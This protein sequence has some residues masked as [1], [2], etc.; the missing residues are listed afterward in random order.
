MKTVKLLADS[1]GA[2]YKGADIAFKGFSIDSRTLKPGEIFVALPNVRDGHDFIADAV[3]KGAAAVLVSKPVET[4][5]PTI[6]VQNTEKALGALAKVW[7]EQFSLPILAITGSSGKTTVKHLTAAILQRRYNT[8]V[9]PK[10]LNNHL[11]LPLVLGQ[12]TAEHDVAVLEMGA[13]LPGEIGYLADIAEPSVGL[14]TLVNPCHIE[15]FGSVESI[16]HTKG[17]L[18]SHLKPGSVALINQADPFCG[19]WTDMASHC[20]RLFFSVDEPSDFYAREIRVASESAEFELVTPEG[21][22]EIHLPLPGHHNVQ[23]A[24]CAAALALTAGADLNTIQQGLQSVTSAERRLQIKKISPTLWII[25]DS[26]NA[27]PTT[28]SIALDI[29][30]AYPARKLCFMGDMGELLL[31]E[32]RELHAAVGHKA[33]EVG[34]EA[35]YGVGILSQEACR[36]FGPKAHNFATQA[37][38]LEV[39][40][41]LLSDEP[42]I[43]LVKGSRGAKMDVVADAIVNWGVRLSSRV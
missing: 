33:R 22:I 17:E 19:L 11:G 38:L 8:L 31:T 3:Q 26:Y 28:F 4:S 32:A 6:T 9:P 29:L 41:T 23:N 24:V 27:S 16:A 15:R 30:A 12:L 13:R 1:I 18:F 43:C 14:I 42:T 35:L 5:V 21:A 37:Q 7:R 25:D 34:V 2:H 39:L 36:A 20:H 40:P 10:N